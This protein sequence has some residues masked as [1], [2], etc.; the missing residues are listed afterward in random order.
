MERRFVESSP[1]WERK[2]NLKRTLGNAL[3]RVRVNPY[4]LLDKLYLP[5]DRKHIR[6]TRNI[7]LIP[8]EANRRGGKYSYAEWAHVIGIFQTLIF[9]HLPRKDENRILDVGC[10]TGLLGISSEP[11]LGHNGRYVGIDVTKEDVEFC[12]RHYPAP[13]FE[14]IH[15]DV[16]NPAYAPSQTNAKRPWPVESASFDLVTALSVWTH[17]SEDDALFYFKEISRV[18]KPDGRAIVT[19]FLIDDAYRSSLNAKSTEEG[20]FHM[21]PRDRWVFDRPSYGSDA[22]RHPKWATVPESAIGVTEIGL[23][24]LIASSGMRLVNHYPGNWKEIPGVFFQDVLVF[25][26][27]NRLIGN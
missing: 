25:E 17:L 18:L 21:T 7:R 23:D 8:T 5:R 9:V 4:R 24:R 3:Q 10:G 27:A 19:L 20:R 6:R 14:F 11:F 1:R 16:N 12:R 13:Q 22:W 26:K 15:F 2:M